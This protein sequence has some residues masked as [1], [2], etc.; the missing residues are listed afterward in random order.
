MLAIARQLDARMPTDGPAEWPTQV[1]PG[2]QLPLFARAQGVDSGREE[3]AGEVARGEA[4]LSPA[5][6]PALSPAL[7]P[8]L[9]PALALVLP[10]WG[11][12]APWNSKLVY[13]T[14]IESAER[15]FWAPSFAQGR[16]V[17]AVASFFEPHATETQRNPA[18]GRMGKRS[19]VFASPGAAPGAG[20]N[21]GPN[22]A[23]GAG[24]LFLGAVCLDGRASIVTTEPSES[25]APIHPR[26][27]LV[28]DASEIATWLGPDWHTLAN[29][30]NVRLEARP[31]HEDEPFEQLSLF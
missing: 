18:T 6:A 2:Q 1:R 30:S 16:A 28:L 15:A 12:L 24:P 13:N 4:A 25:V 21:A 20:P 26:M 10:T 17:A 29:R 9:A 7:A 27:P 5:L 11:F 23:S 31:E 3:H 8:V 22:A 14:R 19:Y